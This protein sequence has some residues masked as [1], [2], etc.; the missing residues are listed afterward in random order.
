MSGVNLICVPRGLRCACMSARRAQ[1]RC[2]VSKMQMDMLR[3]GP[4]VVVRRHGKVCRVLQHI[5]KQLLMPQH[6]DTS[7][8]APNLIS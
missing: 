4:N 7:T 5:G 8:P 2:S 3:V 1:L 6:K